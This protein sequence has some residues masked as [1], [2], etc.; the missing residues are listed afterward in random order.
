MPR[1]YQHFCGAARALD[2]IGE[3]WALLV[4]RE[5]VGGPKR[6]T[7]LLAG[8][9][10]VSTN[11]LASRLAELEESKVIYK[12]LLPPP[13]GVSVYELTSYGRELEPIL[14]QL[15]RWGAHSLDHSMEVNMRA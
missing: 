3:R 14:L 8:L 13:A 4:V 7:D 1:S 6:F 12:R 2:L 5:L 10:G 15:A 11:V 9:Y